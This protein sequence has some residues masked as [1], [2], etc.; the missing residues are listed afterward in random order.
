VN[1]AAKPSVLFVCVKNAGKS[2]MAAGLI[3]KIAG[4]AVQVYSAGT[5]PGTAINALSAQAPNEVGVD[6]TAHTANPVDP[7]L[8]R[9]VHVVVLGQEAHVDPA[10]GTQFENW[11]IDE[12]FDRGI[13]GIER[14]RLV[15]DHIA[16]RGRDLSVRLL[17]DHSV[18]NSSA[19]VN[20]FL[21]RSP[22]EASLGPPRWVAGL[23]GIVAVGCW[24]RG[25]PSLPSDDRGVAARLGAGQDRL[26]RPGWR[27]W[28]RR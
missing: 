10:S 9:T 11:D 23:G 16:T 4:D 5:K 14:M 17:H 6:I 2:Q 24:F 20:S 7:Q 26:G 19:E 13:D 22:S 18:E 1:Q 3:T 28:L 21:H 25:G 15:R 27:L 12:P 8:I